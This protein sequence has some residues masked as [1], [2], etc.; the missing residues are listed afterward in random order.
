[1]KVAFRADASLEIGTGHIMRCLTLAD[2][3]R[4][5]GAECRFLCRAQP[6]NLIDLLQQHGYRVHTI[7]GSDAN[8]TE[9][10]STAPLQHAGWLGGSQQQDAAACATVLAETPADWLIVDHYALDTSWERALR[11]HCNKLMVIDD[12]ADRAHRADLLLDQNLGHTTDDYALL[13]PDACTLLIGPE[14]SLLRP[15]FAQL[16]AYSLARRGHPQLHRLLVNLGGIDKDNITV[17]VLQALEDCKLPDNAT[18]T[19]VMG[20]TAPWVDQVRQQAARMRWTTEV[21]V[22]TGEM[23]RIMAESDLAIGAAGST[24]WERCC[25]GLPSLVVPVAAN[26]VHSANLLQQAGAVHLLAPDTGLATSLR[27]AMENVDRTDTL[28]TMSHAAAQLVDGTGASRV[29]ETVTDG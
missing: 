22:G 27:Q 29:A 16:R 12:L 6:G 9:S 2:A 18:I 3:L 20:S 13:V 14:Y 4:E 15:E 25:L 24:S 7:V 19:V 28:A 11:A 26:Q 8:A 10:A 17:Q 23:A 1:V 21:I 5:Q